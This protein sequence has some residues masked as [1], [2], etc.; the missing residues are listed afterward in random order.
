MAFPPDF[1]DR[2][3]DASDIIDVISQYVSLKKR[4]ANHL[5]LCPFHNEKTPSFSV[6]PAKGIYKCF[7]CGAGG[8]V[9]T[10]IMQRE[11]MQFPESVEFLAKRLGMDIPQTTTPEQR[12]RRD[13]L[14]AAANHG[15]KFFRDQYKKS[16]F[17]QD[18]L[19][20]RTFSPELAERMEIG[21]APD[22][23]D[24][25]T[26]FLRG[27]QKEMVTVGLLREK[28]GR[29]YDYFRNRLIFPIRDLSGRVCA[30]GGRYLGTE[31]EPA[32]YLNSPETPIYNKGSLLYNIGQSREAV[33][34]GGFIYLVEGYT[35]LLR[36]LSCG[37][38]NCA[39]GLGTA[40]TSQQARLIRRYTDKVKLLYDGDEAGCL[41]A[42]KGA[43]ILHS[44]GLDA[45]IISMPPEHDPDS[46]LL[47]KGK[48][49]LEAMPGLSLL[50]F[51][52]K[53]A[54][55]DVNNRQ[56]RE[57]LA[58]EML[59]S[60]LSYSG[61]MKRSLALEAISEMLA[62]PVPALTN[63][64]KQLMRRQPSESDEDTVITEILEF[65]PVEHP[66]R[67]LIRILVN[68][69]SSREDVFTSMAPDILS[70]QVLKKI[71]TTMKSLFLQGQLTDVHVLLNEF[72]D[73]AEKN[74]I[75]ECALWEIPADSEVLLKHALLKLMEFSRKRK[76]AALK[77]EIKEAEA[78]GDD[79]TEIRKKLM[80]L[81]SEKN[82]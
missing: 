55:G 61:E 7:G 1:I 80:S 6:S 75:A 5:G 43:R 20:S 50:K 47:E 68:D 81:M 12:S 76:T 64:L 31:D 30:F 40:L 42:I 38:E 21:Y 67:D 57:V 51:Q 63:E 62:I 39:A 25:F 28:E 34:D 22:S 14:Y 8:N 3:R 56:T 72:E 2:V 59:E 10:F 49:G 70:N 74:F 27:G 66:E 78:R 9:F 33:R 18:Y 23:W 58:R 41:A 11:K 44:A 54:G 35:D 4:G 13:R 46:F 29:Y 73:P 24:A 37:I 17:A 36:L 48:D 77:Q 52:L 16:S 26:N 65:A 45:E 19:K 82:I 71:F 53:L 60:V 32:K 79:T 69:L 15:H